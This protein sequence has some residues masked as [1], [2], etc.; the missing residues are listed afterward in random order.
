MDP[1][2]DSNECE[3]DCDGGG[4]PVAGESGCGRVEDSGDMVDGM[5]DVTVDDPVDV[6][7]DDPVDV[8]S[9]GV[10]GDVSLC[11]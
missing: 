6:T 1:E 3:G 11:A 10:L 4:C 5:V 2:G 9:N 7:V 8:T